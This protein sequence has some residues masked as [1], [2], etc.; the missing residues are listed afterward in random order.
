MNLNSVSIFLLQHHN[1][2]NP[3]TNISFSIPAHGHVLL[4]IYN[5]LGQKIITLVDKN[6][7]AG[8]HNKEFDGRQLSSG[9]YL[10]R[11]QTSDYSAV[12]KMIYL[13]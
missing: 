6:L 2:F 12:K 10:Y 8:G 3:N 4:E 5:T 9:V 13:K 1:P 7:S 11:I